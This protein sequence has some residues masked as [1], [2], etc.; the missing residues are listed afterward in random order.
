MLVPHYMWPAKQVNEA[1]QSKARQF[2]EENEILVTWLDYLKRFFFLPLV[3]NQPTVNVKA[4]VRIKLFTKY[5][6]GL[7]ISVERLCLL[8]TAEHANSLDFRIREGEV[9]Y[10]C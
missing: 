3:W 6:Q 5:F 10:L 2:P 8:D 1:I 4:D 9:Q 7:L